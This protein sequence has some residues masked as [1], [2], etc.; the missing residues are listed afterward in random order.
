MDQDFKN[1]L[2]GVGKSFVESSDLSLE[3]KEAAQSLMA[4]L[5]A[6]NSGEA[7]QKALMN[8]AQDAATLEKVIAFIGSDAGK[9][10]LGAEK[11]AQIAGYVET[12]KGLKEASGISNDDLAGMAGSILKM[13]K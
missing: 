5:S 12:L 2:M 13:M 3:I 4:A 9:N 8:I 6:E 10:L 7:V 11:A 1:S